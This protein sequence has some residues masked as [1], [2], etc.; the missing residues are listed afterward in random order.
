VAGVGVKAVKIHESRGLVIQ[1]ALSMF[2]IFSGLNWLCRTFGGDG[3]PGFLT[4]SCAEGAGI[5]EGSFAPLFAQWSEA[6][7][8][9]F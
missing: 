4:M 7:S 2:T 8:D 9:L 3:L 6:C 5:A 1:T